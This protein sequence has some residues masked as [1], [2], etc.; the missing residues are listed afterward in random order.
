MAHVGSMPGE[1]GHVARHRG[2]GRGWGHRANGS[3]L[4]LEI[5]YLSQIGVSRNFRGNLQARAESLRNCRG[6]VQARAESLSGNCRNFWSSLRN[7][8]TVA[9]QRAAGE[10]F[11]AQKQPD[12]VKIFDFS[13]AT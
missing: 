2:R 13:R 4:A 11:L 10:T 12:F 1:R 9:S 6:N 3:P 7:L 5:R 8:P